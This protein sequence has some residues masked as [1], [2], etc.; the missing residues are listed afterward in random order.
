MHFNELSL[1]KDTQ[2]VVYS[3]FLLLIVNLAGAIE[4]KNLIL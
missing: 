1:K 4:F 3:V 2:N